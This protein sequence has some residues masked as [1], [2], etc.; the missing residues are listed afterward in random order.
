MCSAHQSTAKLD[1]VTRIL[2][3]LKGDLDAKKLTIE[4]MPPFYYIHAT[5]LPTM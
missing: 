5:R 3:E 2:S 1:D 4:R